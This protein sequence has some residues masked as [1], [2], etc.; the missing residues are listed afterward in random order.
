[1]EKSLT[2]FVSHQLAY[3]EMTGRE[4][5]KKEY[6]LLSTQDE[7]FRQIFGTFDSHAMKSRY[8]SNPDAWADRL[9]VF[10]EPDHSGFHIY[11]LPLAFPP[12][13]YNYLVDQRSY[14]ADQ[15]GAIRMVYVNHTGEKCPKNAPILFYVT[16][17]DIREELLKLEKSRGNLDH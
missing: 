9:E 8:S 5:G 3:A 11:V 15:T 6:D 13:P 2:E 17:P 16:T 7:E 10:Y 1:L 12:F 14:Y 4:T